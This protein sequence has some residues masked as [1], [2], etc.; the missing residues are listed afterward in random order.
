[1]SE[2]RETLDFYDAAATDYADR[3]SS[4]G[5]PDGDLRAFMDA[6]M[7]GALVL[8][9]GCGPGR[10]AALLREAGFQV[11]AMDASKGMIRTARERFGIE[12]RLA[13]FDMLDAETRYDGVWA[14]FSLLHAPRAEMP[15]HLVRI[16]RALKPGGVLHLGLKL[17]EGEERDTLGRF[18]SYFSEAELTNWLTAAAFTIDHRRVFEATGMV[19]IPEP[20]IV[21]RAHA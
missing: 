19:G 17:G 1:M 2:D 21:L 15:G 12:A 14:N 11:D 6:L 4:A 3:F 13:T 7:P 18:Y 16:R 20:S 10:S 9:L 8:D 5:K